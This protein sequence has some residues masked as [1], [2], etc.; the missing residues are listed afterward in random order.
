LFFAGFFL[1]ASQVDAALTLKLESSG[2]TTKI[3]VDGSSDDE[4]AEPGVV[5][6]KKP[7]DMFLV[8]ATAGQSKPYVGGDNL[9]EFDLSCVTSTKAAGGTLKISLSDT[10]FFLT[11]YTGNAILTSSI[12]GTTLG[13]TTYQSYVDRTNTVFGTGDIT[14]G[15]QEFVGPSFGGTA[16]K[17]YTQS[18]DFSDDLS[19][20]DYDRCLPNPKFWCGNYGGAPALH[21]FDRQ[22]RLDR[23][24]PERL[25]G[26]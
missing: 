11:I 22:F 25:P 8:Q 17:P 26:C 21:R 18:G 2:G 5:E 7:I 3:V 24:E 13:T 9:A 6:Y 19:G 1:L 20:D 4:N 14:S 16:T 23:Y 12:G 10:D 15:L